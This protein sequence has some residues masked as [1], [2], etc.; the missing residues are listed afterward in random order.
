M[1]FD[2]NNYLGLG[3]KCLYIEQGIAQILILMRHIRTT[4]DNGKL[5]EIVLQWWQ[6]IAGTSFLL[7]EFPSN[8][9]TY[10]GNNWFTSLQQFLYKYQGKLFIPLITQAIPKFLWAKDEAI[11]DRVKTSGFGPNDIK[12]F[13]QVR[14]WMGVH[15]LAEI[16]NASGTA[17]TQEKRNRTR[18]RFTNSI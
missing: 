4:S 6:L 15:S 13:N 17:I 1:K 7:L 10:T 5:A 12:L 16:C 11:M 9:T 3:L 2:S 8:T 14:L 18:S